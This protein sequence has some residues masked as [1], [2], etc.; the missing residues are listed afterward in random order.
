MKVEQFGDESTK[1]L[2]G[3]DVIVTTSYGMPSDESD[4][5]SFDETETKKG[6]DIQQKFAGNVKKYMDQIRKQL[7][8]KKTAFSK[9]A[10]GGKK[11]KHGAEKMIG[12]NAKDIK[13]AKKTLNRIEGRGNKRSRVSGGDQRASRGRRKRK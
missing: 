2:F 13:L 9:N 6:V 10:K 1:E 11:G 7:P 5:D 12:G 8:S 3:G 4:N